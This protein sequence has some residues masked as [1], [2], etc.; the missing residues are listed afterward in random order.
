MRLRMSGIVW[1]LVWG[2]AVPALAQDDLPPLQ[3]PVLEAGYTSES[4]PMST[5]WQDA[6]PPVPNPVPDMPPSA[7]GYPQTGGL[8]SYAS[9]GIPAPRYAQHPGDGYYPYAPVAWNACC[10]YESGCGDPTEYKLKVWSVCDI[11]HELWNEILFGVVDPTCRMDPD[12]SQGPPTCCRKHGVGLL[13][14]FPNH[15]DEVLAHRA[16]ACQGCATSDAMYPNANPPACYHNH[17]GY[18][19]ASHSALG[20]RYAE[21]ESTLDITPI[22]RERDKP[23]VAREVYT[24]P[25]T[26]KIR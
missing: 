18:G 16:R 17:G 25:T 1:L 13:D 11:G 20:N 23:R 26:M 15:R 9:Y 24:V 12:C 19:Y 14:L 7:Y 10:A 5:F 3:R 4:E 2:I 8:G 21:N 6:P 22:G